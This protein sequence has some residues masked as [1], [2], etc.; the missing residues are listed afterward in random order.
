MNYPLLPTMNYRIALFGT[1]ADPPTAGH[2]EICRWL[3]QH[4]DWVAVWASD[5]PFKSHQTPLTH[6]SMMLNLMLEEMRSPSDHPNEYHSQYPPV[7]NIDLHQNLSS[8]RTLETVAKAHQLW[9]S[10]AD[11]TVVIGADLIPQLASWYRITDLL[12]QVQLLVVPRSGYPLEDHDLQE[13]KLMGGKIAIAHV[14]P[15]GVSSTDYRKHGD[16]T[17]ITPPIAAYINRENLYPCQNLA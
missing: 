12:Q 14:H 7:T 17:T 15:P 2:Q 10:E 13:L 16:R 3:S 8:P 4:Y 9:G 6:R 11:L 5:N 1:S